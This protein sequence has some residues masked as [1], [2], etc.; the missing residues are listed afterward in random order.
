MALVKGTALQSS[1]RY[2]RE[3]FGEAAVDGV[4]RALPAEHGALLAGARNLR[5]SHSACV[6]RGDPVC[7][8][9]GTRDARG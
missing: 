4:L 7:R 2:V 6:R 3:R 8:F 9:E 1:L 5:S